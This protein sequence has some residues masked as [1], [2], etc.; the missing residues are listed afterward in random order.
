[1]LDT[2][3]RGSVLKNGARSTLWNEPGL[4]IADM[5]ARAVF[6]DGR[7]RGQT[8]VNLKTNGKACFIEP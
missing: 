4:Q 7:V 3:T 2:N 5:C 1:L 6:E 8:G